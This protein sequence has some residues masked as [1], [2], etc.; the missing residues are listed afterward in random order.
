MS[1]FRTTQWSLVFAAR[2]EGDAASTALA[3]LCRRYRGPVL[4]YIRCLGHASADADDLTQAFFLRLLER[5]SDV[6][7]D[8]AR[9]RFRSY[10]LGALKHFLADANAANSAAKRGGGLRHAALDDEF[11]AHIVDPAPTPER[12][13]DRAFAFAAIERALQ[14]LREEARASG[15]S[16]QL[17]LLDEFLLESRE[18]GVQQALALRLQVRANTLAVALKRWRERL[19]ALI[20]DEV[21]QTVADPAAV[22]TEVRALRAALRAPD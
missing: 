15:K 19:S 5:R 4:T 2:N 7:A 1:A 21:A 20:R 3:E 14:R 22:E 8:P 17:A 10:L 13:F 12:A 18:S 6:G 9:G 11:A 16:A